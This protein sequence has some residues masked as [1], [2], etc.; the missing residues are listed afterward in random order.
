MKMLG[1]VFLCIGLLGCKSPD[2]EFEEHLK[3]LSS[4][5]FNDFRTEVQTELP[6]GWGCGQVRSLENRT[7]FD[8]ESSNN[9][10]S[11][12]ISRCELL[13]QK[14]WN[15]R[16]KL[17]KR[18][19]DTIFTDKAVTA[20]KKRAA[21]VALLAGQTLPEGIFAKIAVSVSLSEPD[22]FD[23]EYKSNSKE[24]KSVEQTILAMLKL[25]KES[26]QDVAHDG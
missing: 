13:T 24:A 11:I 19:T 20:E 16:F 10:F 4:D 15:K 7:L 1:I 6:A 23:P 26:E 22:L 8:V 25:Y 17:A 12:I 9:T 5:D 18:A 2:P 21:V 3:A 14:E